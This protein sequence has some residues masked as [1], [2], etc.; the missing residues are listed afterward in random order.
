MRSR[1]PSYARTAVTRAYSG[2]LAR[3]LETDFMRRHDGR[4]PAAYPEV[5]H[6]TVPLRRAS[7]RAERADLLALWAGT[8]W[9]SARPVPAATV[10]AEFAH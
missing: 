10:V 8:G 2:R 7:A 6:V 5:H 1:I 3:G 4:A 9:R